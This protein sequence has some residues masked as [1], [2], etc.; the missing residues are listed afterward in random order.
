VIALQHAHVV[1]HQTSPARRSAFERLEFV[2]DCHQNTSESAS[3]YPLS[4]SLL[5]TGVDPCRS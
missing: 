5:L 1:T 3:T 2:S 4:V